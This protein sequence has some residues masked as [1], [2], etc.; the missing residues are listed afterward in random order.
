MG[1][2]WRISRGS[3]GR[4][5]TPKS[6]TTSGRNST[7][8]LASEWRAADSPAP[9][10]FVAPPG[11]VGCETCGKCGVS[12]DD[13]AIA[14]SEPDSLSEA[15]LVGT[16][17]GNTGTPGGDWAPGTPGNEK[18]LLTEGNDIGDENGADCSGTAAGIVGTAGT[19]GTSDTGRA[20]AVLGCSAGDDAGRVPLSLCVVAAAG[21]INAGSGL[22]GTDTP[23]TRGN[24]YISLA[25]GM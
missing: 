21:D 24:E 16:D 2:S 12:A 5:V 15:A 10:D 11:V 17:D 14:G 22:P 1:K 7:G 6:G 23:G 18:R 25:A 19:E 8:S 13:P 4:F 20:D 3:K 9:G